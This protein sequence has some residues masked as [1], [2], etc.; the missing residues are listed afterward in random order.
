MR[1]RLLLTI[2]CK[3]A[4]DFFDRGLHTRTA[5]ARVPW[6]QLGF[7]VVDRDR[8]PYKRLLSQQVI[9]LSVSK[10][11]AA[12]IQRDV[13]SGFLFFS[14]F[15]WINSADKV[16]RSSS[17]GSLSNNCSLT[18]MNKYN[19]H[20]HSHHHQHRHHTCTLQV[21]LEVQKRQERRAVARKPL[22]AGVILFGSLTTVTPTTSWSIAKLRKPYIQSSKHIGA[23]QNLTQNGHA[24]S[25][26]VTCFGVSGKT[27]GD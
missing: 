15:W 4:V 13:T 22:D 21:G 1:P 6:R 27:V 23:K 5:V 19:H 14:G 7:L 16:K 20:H 11:R 2:N 10:D 8:A 18:H 3:F 9:I 24:R 26:R 17:S 12:A 25:F